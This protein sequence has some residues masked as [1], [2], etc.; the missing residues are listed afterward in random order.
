MGSWYMPPTERYPQMILVIGV[1][2]L[3][4]WF[5]VFFPCIYVQLVGL[6]SVVSGHSSEKCVLLLAS[7][8]NV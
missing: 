8:G 3:D 4:G 5:L 7:I 2:K 1:N 6:C